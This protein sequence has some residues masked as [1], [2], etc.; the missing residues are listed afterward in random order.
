ML[1]FGALVLKEPCVYAERMLA[2]DAS[3][4]WKGEAV[5]SVS[6]HHSYRFGLYLGLHKCPDGLVNTVLKVCNL[7]LPDPSSS[8][9][10]FK[11]TRLLLKLEM[12]VLFKTL[13]G[14][15]KFWSAGGGECLPND[16]ETV[17]K[18]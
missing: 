13:L 10:K 12:L 17:A 16:K 1:T 4:G 8:C 11:I 3:S 6:A 7:M 5:G 18:S 9:S 2:L 14:H 15:I